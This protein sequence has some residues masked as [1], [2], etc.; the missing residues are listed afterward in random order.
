MRLAFSL[1]AMASTD[2]SSSSELSSSLSLDAAEDELSL[3]RLLLALDVLT[4]SLNKAKR[5]ISSAAMASR[6]STFWERRALACAVARRM[7]VSRVRAV[8]GEV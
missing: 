7:R 3:R 1:A 6:S 5:R 2:W 8:R 4:T